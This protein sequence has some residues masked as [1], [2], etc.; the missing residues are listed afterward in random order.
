M[1]LVLEWRRDPEQAFRNCT[2]DGWWPVWSSYSKTGGTLKIPCV[3]SLPVEGFECFDRTFH[4]HR[5]LHPPFMPCSFFPI[6]V[7]ISLSALDALT[8]PQ[9]DA[10]CCI[11]SQPDALQVC[12]TCSL[13][14]SH[15]E[16]AAAL[17]TLGNIHMDNYGKTCIIRGR[18]SPRCFLV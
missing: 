9:R 13:A 12:R 15:L 5:R 7:V 6:N 14:V 16:K 3:K 1:T 17:V 4:A 2:L 8:L 18:T 11:I 10:L